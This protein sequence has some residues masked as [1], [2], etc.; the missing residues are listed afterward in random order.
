MSLN[1]NHE[2]CQAVFNINLEL[3]GDEPLT[4]EKWL[5]IP[6]DKRPRVHLSV[7]FDMGWQQRGFSSVSGHAFMIGAQS[8]L[9]LAKIVCGKDCGICKW[10]K[11][12][13]V[14]VRRHTCPM[15]YEGS[16][17]GMESTAALLLTI[18]LFVEKGVAV[19]EIV[20]DDD[21]SM[22]ALVRHS[23]DEKK[24][25]KTCFQIGLTRQQL[26]EN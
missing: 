6:A 24:H 2:V 25:E 26:M 9:I 1:E 22:K 21:S 4:Y 16:S 15:N 3:A 7:S 18:K 23:Y 13:N 10:A 20:A 14:E 11:K 19:E 5:E 8:G 17:K 12:N